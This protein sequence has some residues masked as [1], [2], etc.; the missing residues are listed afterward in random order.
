MF[1]RSAVVTLGTILFAVVAQAQEE[2]WEAKRA[3]LRKTCGA[4]SRH[5]TCET[6]ENLERVIEV[7]LKK[8]AP[9]STAP[10]GQPWDKQSTPEYFDRVNGRFHLTTEEQKLLHARGFVVPARLEYSDY[11]NAI[12][13]VHQSQLP[14]FVSV[15]A[16][17]HAIYKGN[18]VMIAE[19]EVALSESLARVLEQMH[20]ALPSARAAYTPETFADLDLYIAVAHSLLLAD[21]GP[22]DPISAPL[23]DR[24]DELLAAIAEARGQ[25]TVT[26][27]GRDRVID[28]SAFTPRGHYTGALAPYFRAAMWLSRLE[29]NLVS[30]SCRAAQPGLSP[31]SEETPREAV[32]AL[33]LSD[34]AKRA[35]VLEDLGSI[36]EAWTVL[37]GGREDVSLAQLDGL[38]ERANIDS[39]EAPDAAERLRRVIGGNFR[40]TVAAVPMPQ[41]VEEL[42]V[43][44]SMLGSRV[45]SG[46]D[47]ASMLVHDRVPDRFDLDVADVA[48]ALGND[49][50]RV[51]LEDELAQFPQL[52]GQ[53]DKARALA[54]AAPEGDDLAG[55]WFAAIRSLAQKPQGVLPSFMATPAYEDLRLNTTAAAWGQIRH[56]YVLMEATAYDGF[57]CEIP[58]G[59]VEPAPAMYE[60]LIA[61]ADRGARALARLGG[62]ADVYVG[63]P[64][65]FARLGKVLRVLRAIG[66]EELA[67]HPLSE[68]M[69]QFLAMAVEVSAEVEGMYEPSCVAKYRGWY[70]ELF[71]RRPYDEESPY[72]F[73]S[74]EF[75][76]DVF[77]SSNSGKVLHVGARRPRL[78]L[79]VVDAG[80][81]PRLAVGPVAHAFE[82]RTDGARL[83]DEAVAGLDEASLVEP[84]SKA[85]TVPRPAAPNATIRCKREKGVELSCVAKAEAGANC[86]LTIARL[87]YHGGVAESV[88]RPLGTVPARFVFRKKVPFERVKRVE[89]GNYRAEF[90]AGTSD[91]RLGAVTT[92]E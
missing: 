5:T 92:G 82:Y 31:N 54:A 39:V 88:T 69:K 7:I 49:R 33:A 27:F 42:P 9:I 77:A 30:R 89:C 56:N 34:L 17:L 67:N 46:V 58:D 70:F 83:S 4:A 81:G 24:R 11:A 55:A 60:E 35:K 48:Y 16:V 61:Y 32:L 76:V 25:E 3:A 79:F 78:G 87:D 84:W 80:G 53:L 44:A 74:P 10:T 20:G 29:L 37:A 8:Q 59:Y 85:Y 13:E 51:Y 75:M 15:D 86:A 14:V 91:I 62:S 12:H 72:A 36:E 21:D 40:R 23:K 2:D 71:P 22:A 26:L 19:I 65:Y 1:S 41:G 38:R 90:P 50:A 18:D 63:D 57:G 47:L 43:V 64:E 73:A 45:G 52:A 66:E 28:F 6:S 68:D